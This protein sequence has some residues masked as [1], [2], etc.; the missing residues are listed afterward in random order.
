M[1]E[2]LDRHHEVKASS[3]RNFGFVMA[4]FFALLAFW[5]LVTGHGYVRIWPGL[6]SAAFL[7]LALLWTAPLA[8]LNRL[9]LKFGLLLHRIVSPI[10]L[11]ILYYGTVVPMGLLMRAVGKDP[12]RRKWEADAPSYWIPRDPPGPSPDS[13]RNQY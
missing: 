2:N 6:V 3:D 8:P 13:M 1:H 4:G 10:I 9:W 5:P 12:M 11:A 7:V